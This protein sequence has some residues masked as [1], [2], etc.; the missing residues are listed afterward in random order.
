MRAMLKGV[1]GCQN[2]NTKEA[3]EHCRALGKRCR[4]VLGCLTSAFA[5]E[6]SSLLDAAAMPNDLGERRGGCGESHAH[7]VAQRRNAET[8]QMNVK[9]KCDKRAGTRQHES[10]QLMRNASLGPVHNKLSEFTGSGKRGSR[11]MGRTME[12]TVPGMH[13]VFGVN[14][15]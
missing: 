8:P 13:V 7:R 6:S 1:L 11:S 10:K 12:H 9:W 15:C 2:P 14:L 4:S 3:R 5:L